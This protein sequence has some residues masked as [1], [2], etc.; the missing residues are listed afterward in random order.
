V[1]EWVKGNENADGWNEWARDIARVQADRAATEVN[2]QIVDDLNGFQD[3]LE[4]RLKH[5]EKRDADLQARIDEIKT[6]LDD[7]E[8]RVSDLEGSGDTQKVVPLLTFKGGRDA[9]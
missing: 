1:R 4:A 2:N 9:A 8:T 7:L 6:R 5:F 3:A